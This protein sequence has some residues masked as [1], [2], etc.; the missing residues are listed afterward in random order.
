MVYRMII[1]APLWFPMKINTSYSIWQPY[2]IYN[3]YPIISFS[4]WETSS[5]SSVLPF[6]TLPEYRVLHISP[7][8]WNAAYSSVGTIH[9]AI[10]H[11]LV[12]S[13]CPLQHVLVIPSW[14]D[15]Y[16][17]LWSS[18]TMIDYQYLVVS[19]FLRII[20]HIDSSS[21]VPTR[22][23]FIFNHLSVLK[24]IGLHIG[25][26]FNKRVAQFI[27]IDV[28]HFHQILCLYHIHK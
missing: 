28:I 18:P 17:T 21:T 7:Q 6:W 13:E 12:P 26:K 19:C 11:S 5:A 16:R 9:W 3:I 1:Y 15:L 23:Q 8:E 25:R 4:L 14:L 27:L 2:L 24:I 20:F 22:I 10:L